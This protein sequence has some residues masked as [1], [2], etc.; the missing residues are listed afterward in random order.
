MGEFTDTPIHQRTELLIPVYSQ[1][2]LFRG[3]LTP[4]STDIHFNAST[5]DSLWKHFGKRKN[6]WQR[7]IFF[8]SPKCFLLNHR[9]VSPLVNIFDII[10]L[11][12]AKL[13]EPKIG[14]WGKGI[15]KVNSKT[16]HQS[17]QTIQS[18]NNPDR[19]NFRK[20]FGKRRKCRWTAFSSFPIFFF[21]LSQP[22]REKG[23]NSQLI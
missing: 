2:H 21:C 22:K 3:G 5:T 1:K 12:A 20:H 16:H 14:V 6:C 9:S 8:F 10:T 19:K 17:Y 15:N 23:Y 11:F 7:A 4:Y 18:Y 13:E